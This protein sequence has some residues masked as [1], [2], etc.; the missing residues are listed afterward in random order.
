[1]EREPLLPFGELTRHADPGAPDVELRMK[2][3]GWIDDSGGPDSAVPLDLPPPHADHLRTH[4]ET[5][6][7]ADRAAC[8][9]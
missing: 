1:M 4:P 6:P 8:R 2:G 9:R 3:R 5:M 7:A